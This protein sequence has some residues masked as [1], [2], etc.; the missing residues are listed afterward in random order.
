MRIRL[1]LT[2]SKFSDPY[3]RCMWRICIHRHAVHGLG[4]RDL[5]LEA[6]KS[7]AVSTLYNRQ[8]RSYVELF[9]ET[10][11]IRDTEIF[12]EKIR[13]HYYFLDSKT[14]VTVYC[15]TKQLVTLVCKQQYL[16]INVV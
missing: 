3:S 13:N 5:S 6:A 15:S 8:T 4:P 7:R 11:L 10:E 12:G 9:G 16:S 14:I 1:Y 2:L